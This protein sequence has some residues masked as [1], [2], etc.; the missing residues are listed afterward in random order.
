MRLFLLSLFALIFLTN[1]S[2][3]KNKQ[4][5]ELD[6]KMNEVAEQY[7]KLVLEIG[8]YKPDYVDAYYGPDEW[9]PEKSQVNQIDST[10]I[11]SPST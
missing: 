7:V 3:Q 2:N 9:L 5:N 11:N 1:C 6:I 10:I 4:I 8:L